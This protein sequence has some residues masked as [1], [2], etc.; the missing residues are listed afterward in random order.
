MAGGDAADPLDVIVEPVG[1][2]IASFSA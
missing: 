2:V 1:G